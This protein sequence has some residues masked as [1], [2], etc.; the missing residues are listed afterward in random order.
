M[1]PLRAEARD[2]Q[3]ALAVAGVR[4]SL[5][6][7]GSSDETAPPPLAV[8]AAPGGEPCPRRGLV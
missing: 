3:G 6:P 8:L 5:D 2:G 7:P 4:M 1:K